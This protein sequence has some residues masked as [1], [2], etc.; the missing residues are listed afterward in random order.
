VRFDV[1][2]V[3]LS[4]SLTACTAGT[5]GLYGLGVDASASAIGDDAGVTFVAT[6][7]GGS[8]TSCAMLG[9]EGAV[10]ILSSAQATNAYVSGAM[11]DGD[12]ATLVTWSES[13]A[14]APG[15]I[16]VAGKARTLGA[17]AQPEAEAVDFPIDELVLA[18]FAG[19]FGHEGVAGV[20]YPGTIHTPTT[21]YCEFVPIEASG[22]R[23]DARRIADSGCTWLQATPTGFDALI[24]GTSPAHTWSL[25]S[26]DSGGSVQRS[27]AL[28]PPIDLGA[29]GIDRAVLGD[30]TF[31]LAWSPPQLDDCG[32]STTLF[33]RHYAEDGHAMG[34]ART[35]GP[36][37]GGPRDH[38][39][40]AFGDGALLSW[41]PWTAG[42][43]QIER[44]DKEGIVIG[45]AQIESAPSSLDVAVWG[46]LAILGW[47]E[48]TVSNGQAIGTRISGQ[49]IAQDGTLGS[50]FS[51]EYPVAYPFFLVPSERGAI[52]VFEGTSGSSPNV[53]AALISCS[54]S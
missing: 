40:V 52:A 15:E 22:R 33:L 32:C 1:Q 17:D 35:V 11:P 31:L 44:L 14:T 2:I 24:P 9:V 18:S 13:P 50:S 54:G 19:G 10:A 47:I 53:S 41:R 6:D 49:V 29:A 30:G 39:V 34:P 37:A 38:R 5:A 26:I 36:I 23:G 4:L 12:R 3:L 27:I 42:F 16:S 46:D 45:T 28:D 43:I 51:F 20:A 7:A 25:V 21:A 8:A 48:E